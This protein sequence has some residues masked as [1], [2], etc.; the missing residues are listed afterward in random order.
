MAN[1]SSNLTPL[2]LDDM[3]GI[4]NVLPISEYT[5]QLQTDTANVVEGRVPITNFSPERQEQ[6][7]NYYR[8][9]ADY[10]N[11]QMPN[12]VAKRTIDT[13]DIV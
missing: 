9:S 2:T 11:D 6:I 1:Q 7:A 4:V 3:R 5:L 10:F 12:Q 8:F 13:L